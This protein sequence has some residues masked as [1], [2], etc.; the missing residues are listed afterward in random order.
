[1]KS[2]ITKEWA[3]EKAQ[4]LKT[5]YAELIY[6]EDIIEK[7]QQNNEFKSNTGAMAVWGRLTRI[8][9]RRSK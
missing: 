8:A 1:M 3:I 5:K 4:D 7:A 2:T 6:V 9:P